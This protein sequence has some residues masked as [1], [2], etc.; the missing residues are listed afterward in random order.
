MT[1]HEPLVPLGEL[2]LRFAE[3]RLASEGDLAGIRRSLEHSGQISALVACVQ[4]N[5][6]EIVDGFKRVRAAR[7]LGLPALRVRAAFG[8]K[9]LTRAKA[10]I[11]HLNS[12][13]GLQDLEEGWLI[14]SL[15]RDDGM[16]QPEIGRLFAHDKSWVSRRLSLAEGLD[17]EIQCQVRLGL[18]SPSP[19]RELARLPRGNQREAAEVVTTKGLTYSQTAKLVRR[20]L[21]LSSNEARSS[22]LN[23]ERNKPLPAPDETRPGKVRLNPINQTFCDIGTMIRAGVR[24]QSFILG[25]PLA[26][27]GDEA[28]SRLKTSLRE[29]ESVI[30]E[31][32]LTIDAA[33]KKESTNG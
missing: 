8:E 21:E 12:S 20:A 14:R 19:A 11:F 24:I 17:E 2:G 15:Y 18:I 13:H 26:A 27:H 25:A 3:F 10:A 29:L 5:G 6:L 23:D 16:T 32:E 30:S 9:E 33:T 1:V 28:S 31:L 22:Y 4:P 7:M